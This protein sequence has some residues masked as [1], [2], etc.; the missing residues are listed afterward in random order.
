MTF[1][2]SPMMLAVTCSDVVGS[3]GNVVSVQAI[4]ENVVSL[5]VD[6]NFLPWKMRNERLVMLNQDSRLRLCCSPQTV[7]STTPVVSGM[8]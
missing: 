6:R 3:M 4:G 2:L 5:V 7:S 1:T 8:V